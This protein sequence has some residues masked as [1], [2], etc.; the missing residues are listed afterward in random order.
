[1]N[2]DDWKALHGL[3]LAASFLP[4]AL[5]DHDLLVWPVPIAGPLVL[6]A[7]IVACVGPLR[8]TCS[9][10]KPGRASTGAIFLTALIAAVS[11]GVLIAY[12][13]IFQPDLAH[14]DRYAPLDFAG[15]LLVSGVLFSIGN[16]FLEEAVFRGILFQALEARMSWVIT[17]LLTSILFGLGH[18]G[19]YP[20]GALG[21]CL[22]GV[23]G[24]A[25]GLLRHVSGGLLLPVAAHAVA[26]ATIFALRAG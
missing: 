21:A 25:L 8:R 13:I 2:S 4:L 9:W 11:S 10:L 24:L 18:A 26:D 20:P 15:N 14:L 1:M 17:V 22:A 6:Y 7:L 19:G 5:L 12:D 16:A 23:Y 3:V